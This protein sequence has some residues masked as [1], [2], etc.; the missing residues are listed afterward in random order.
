MHQF[1]KE[2]VLSA[3]QSAMLGV[4]RHVA[5]CESLGLLPEAERAASLECAQSSQ[6]GPVIA[7]KLVAIVEGELAI[8]SI[9]EAE[10]LML[11][12][13]CHAAAADVFD[14]EVVLMWDN[15]PDVE[16]E[17]IG[18]DERVEAGEFMVEALKWLEWR[19]EGKELSRFE[20]ADEFHGW[21]G[22]GAGKFIG[23]FTEAEKAEMRFRDQLERLLDGMKG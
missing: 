21:F 1:T 2:A 6:I 11:A 20:F 4:S 16:F 10:R 15:G 17:E 12:D 9:P 5:I 8:E 14:S 23:E 19:L 13:L 3:I 7:A 22:L 18:G